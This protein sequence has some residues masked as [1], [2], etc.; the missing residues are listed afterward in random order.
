MALVASLLVGRA[1]AETAPLTLTMVGN[2]TVLI[3]GA[4]RLLTDPFFG[5]TILWGLKRAVPPAFPAPACPPPDLV[6]VSHTH[7]DHYRVKDIRSFPGAPTVVMPW[8]RGRALRRSGLRVVELRPGQVTEQNGVRVTAVRARH[9]WGHCLGY[10]IEMDGRRLYF[11]GDT[12]LFP[13]LSRLADP[14][15]DVMMI[16]FGGTAVVG[17]VWTPAQAARAV[18]TV[19][20][21]VLIPVHW[22]GIRS[23]WRKKSKETPE[24]FLTRVRVAAPATEGR[25]LRAGESYSFPE[26]A[27]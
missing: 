20:P 1:S 4:A 11:S 5:E 16:P 12:K 15:V 14:P 6:L 27:R 3:E 2:A 13:E 23:W 24:A 26:A 7:P 9:M 8:E 22:D 10:L 21:R 17:S 19:R 18:A 25:I